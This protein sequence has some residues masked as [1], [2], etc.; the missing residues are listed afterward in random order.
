M[1]NLRKKNPFIAFF[2]CLFLTILTPVIVPQ[3]R[4]MFFV[5]FLIILFYQKSLPVSLWLSFLCGLIID[6]LSAQSPFGFNACSYTLTTAT[7][8]RQK[9]NFFSDHLS[10]LPIMTFLFSFLTT[11]FEIIILSIFGFHASIGFQWIISDLLLMPCFDALFAFLGFIL[12]P[13]SLQKKS[14]RSIG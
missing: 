1:I 11:I 7:I 2:C 14:K 12:I 13:L 9:R 10:T 3:A 5:P 8:Y 6:L 4:L